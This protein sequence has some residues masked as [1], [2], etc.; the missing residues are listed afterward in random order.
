MTKIDRYVLRNFFKTLVLWYLCLVGLYVVFDLFTNMD[1]II[2]S[3]V[4]NGNIIIT[5]GRYYFFKSFQFFDILVSLLIMTS[6]MITLSTMIRHNEMIPLLAAGVSQLRIILP[7]IGAALLVTFLAMACR[8]LLLPQYLDDLLAKK[9]S[10]VGRK[11]GTPIGGIADHQTGIQLNGDTAFWNDETIE[12]PKFIMPTGLNIYGKSIEAKSAKYMRAS[13]NR[14]AGYMLKEV[15]TPLELLSNDSLK[16][17]DQTV[18][19][20][21]KDAPD[22]VSSTD[23]FVASHITFHQIAGGE[24]WEQYGSTL[25]LVEGARGASLKLGESVYFVIHS[26]VTQPLL[27]MT[28]LLLGLPIILA[29]SDRNVFKAL[30][31]GA[32]LIV[33]FLAVQMICKNVGISYHQPI[34]GAW[35][36][37]IMFIPLAAYSFYDLLR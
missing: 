15:T 8:E 22:W 33:A 24:I 10:E 27:D 25:E 23:C 20:T 12:A 3:G 21:S 37:L 35:F 14:P 30:G 13:G 26:R 11:N 6:A 9:P 31:V 7:I 19:I 28:L 1:S 16:L 17:N 36:P 5:I 18:V 29:K 4:E 32:L 34:L 2:S